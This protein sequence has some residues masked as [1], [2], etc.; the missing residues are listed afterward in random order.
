VF[1][2]LVPFLG[3]TAMATAVAQ[4]GGSG[5]PAEATTVVL[6]HGAFAVAPRNGTRNLNTGEL[7][8]W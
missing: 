1:K 7:L 4:G 5:S 2:F 6:V 3:A 8:G